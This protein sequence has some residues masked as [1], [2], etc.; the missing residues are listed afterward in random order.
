MN[1]IVLGIGCDGTATNA[2]VNVGIVRLLETKFK[3]QLQ[4]IP[5]QLHANELP[6][7]PLMKQLD[8]PTTGSAG[9]LSPLG[10]ALQ[11]I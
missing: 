10:S 2:G 7:L 9:F 3:Q 1:N 6:L 11:I 5:C 8:G 4:W